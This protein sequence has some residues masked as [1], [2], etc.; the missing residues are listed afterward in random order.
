MFLILLTCSE[1]YSVMN[2]INTSGHNKCN[3]VV[4]IKDHSFAMPVKQIIVPAHG[5]KRQNSGK[6][7]NS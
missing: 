7:Q 1:T 6:S 2:S 5:R 4:F 3:A